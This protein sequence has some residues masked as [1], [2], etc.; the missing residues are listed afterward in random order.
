MKKI[1]DRKI[2]LFMMLFLLGMSAPAFAQVGIHSVG[3]NIGS[4][5]PSM[6]YW[7][8]NALTTWG[9]K[10]GGSLYGNLNVEVSLIKVLGLRVGVGYWN[11]ELTESGIQYG[12]ELRNDKIAVQFIPLNF[13]VIFRSPLE[14]S[15]EFGLYGGIGTGIN[16]I[17]MDYTIS[18]PS[19]GENVQSHSGRNTI[20]HLIMGADYKIMNNLAVG[21]EFKY[22]FAKYAQ[23]VL[24]E[25]NLRQEDVSMNGVQLMATIKYLF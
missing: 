12:S 16:F 20:F 4:Y 7:N 18:I 13:D 5:T 11:Q 10:F 9:S 24:V 1:F 19:L 17:S 23:D 3:I 6:D 21:A 22:I 25:T 15:S 8:D 2:L 14:M